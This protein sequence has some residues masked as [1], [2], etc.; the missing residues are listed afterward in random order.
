LPSSAFDVAVAAVCRHVVVLLLL[1]LLHECI[2][3]VWYVKSD[4]FNLY[5]TV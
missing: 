3:F 2:R 4:M 1:P 5:A